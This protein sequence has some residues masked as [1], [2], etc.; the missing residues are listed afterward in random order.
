MNFIKEDMPKLKQIIGAFLLLSI[1]PVFT[2]VIANVTNNNISFVVNAG[3]VYL[4][5]VGV[6]ALALFVV[7][8]I[9]LII[10]E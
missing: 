2:G 4:I 3:I 10:K 8:C 1:L 6:L 9:N 7:F 5:E